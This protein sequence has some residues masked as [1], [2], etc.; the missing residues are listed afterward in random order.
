ME[1]EPS[2]IEISGMAETLAGTTI[3]NTNVVD[4]PQPATDREE[5][6]NLLTSPQELRDQIYDEA[7]LTHRRPLH[8]LG[9]PYINK[10]AFID[11]KARVRAYAALTRTCRQVSEELKPRFWHHTVFVFSVKDL[12]MPWR[13]PSPA[14]IRQMRH[15]RLD[16][17][18]DYFPGFLIRCAFDAT[19]VPVPADGAMDKDEDKAVVKM[20]V[21]VWRQPDI[22]KLDEES[23]YD[24]PES[25]LLHDLTHKDDLCANMAEDELCSKFPVHVERAVAK[26]DRF[27]GPEATLEKIIAP[28]QGGV[29]DDR[30]KFD[31]EGLKKVAQAIENHSRYLMWQ[32]EGGRTAWRRR[33][34]RGRR[35]IVGEGEG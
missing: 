14:T 27:R 15:V 34:R 2:A 9:T 20:E 21:Q 16:Q 1:S 5:S 10:R 3:A 13:S 31:K 19:N 22:E 18:A 17:P 33:G 28:L 29:H 30:G 25:C 12:T 35:G 32:C 4:T 7:L 8:I 24:F 26:A 11:E 23:P 6:P